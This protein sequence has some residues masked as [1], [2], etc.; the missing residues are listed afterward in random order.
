M[1]EAF[2]EVMFSAIYIHIQVSGVNDEF[3]AKQ[4]SG[5]LLVP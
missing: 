1:E 3:R 2:V 5:L 4:V